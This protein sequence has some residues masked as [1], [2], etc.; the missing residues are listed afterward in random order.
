M[1]SC[2]QTRYKLALPMPSALPIAVATADY[3]QALSQ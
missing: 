2:L 1:R 3:H